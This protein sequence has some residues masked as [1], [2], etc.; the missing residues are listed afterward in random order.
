MEERKK[1][2]IAS[3]LESNPEKE[4]VV[5]IKEIV[6]LEEEDKE[7]YANVEDIEVDFFFDENIDNYKNYLVSFSKDTYFVEYSFCK[8]TLG[9]IL[10]N[11][12][13]TYGI[14][15]EDFTKEVS[16]NE[17]VNALYEM[18]CDY[19]ISY[20]EMTQDNKDF[21][22]RTAENLLKQQNIQGIVT[23]KDLVLP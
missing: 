4:F 21:S 18:F 3:L 10:L 20:Q 22:F 15:E 9:N 1:K 17:K 11:H 12:L 23:K 19:V 8:I 14:R 7:W 5:I 16:E 2:E 13:T 6:P